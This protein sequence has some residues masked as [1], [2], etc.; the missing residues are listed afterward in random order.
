MDESELI[1]ER[2][3]LKRSR[4]WWRG[5]AIIVAAGLIAVA[6]CGSDLARRYQP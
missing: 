4:S 2:R 6:A 5:A 3:R 1:A